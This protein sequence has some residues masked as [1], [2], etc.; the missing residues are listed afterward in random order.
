MFEVEELPRAV[1]RLAQAD[2]GPVGECVPEWHKR[3]F[4]AAGVGRRQ[5]DG[6]V[7]HPLGDALPWCPVT[8][9]TAITL[10]ARTSNASSRVVGRGDYAVRVHDAH[11]AGPALGV[12]RSPRAAL[13]R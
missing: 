5:R 4:P 8:H 10:H 3:R 12:D 11:S 6:A 7:G 13:R 2:D 1:S 9:T